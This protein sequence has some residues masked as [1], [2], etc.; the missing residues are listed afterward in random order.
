[1]ASYVTV[2]VEEQRVFG[3]CCPIQGCKNELYEQD[4]TKLVEA[5]ELKAE[6][7]AQ[8]AKL[9]KQDYTSRLSEVCADLGS[10]ALNHSMRLCPRC[11]II[12]QKKSGCNS[13]GCICGHRFQFDA[14]P[15]MKD[16]QSALSYC[17]T[18]VASKHNTTMPEATKRIIV[19]FSTK[20]I[21]KYTLV[22][23]K[24]DSAQISLD[25]AEVHEQARLG[26][27]AAITQLRSARCD[28]RR[29]RL[30]ELLTT[31]LGVSLDEAKALA[32]QARDGNTEAWQ[33]IKKARQLRSRSNQLEEQC[34]KDEQPEVDSVSESTL[35]AEPHS[36][37]QPQLEAELYHGNCSVIIDTSRPTELSL[38]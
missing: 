8:M 5:G 17:R 22:L 20:G 10:T 35:G 1:M 14:A 2:R 3:I 36:F 34:A 32:G 18:D 24:A 9:R 29:A 7:A 31:Q 11:N 25:L 26:Q 13:F 15:S 6:V 16:I 19:A 33:K 30:H 23:R 12:I 4:V 28:L 38:C 37:M 27:R 21:K